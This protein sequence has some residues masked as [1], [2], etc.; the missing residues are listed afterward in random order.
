MIDETHDDID[1]TNTGPHNVTLKQW[2]ACAPFEKLLGMDI[3]ESG[4]GKAVLTM[5]FRYKLAQGL[6]LLHGGALFSL[7]DTA[8]VMAMKSLLPDS[9]H[10]ATISAECTFLSAVTQGTVTAKAEV[11]K[12]EGRLLYGNAIV[13]DTHGKQVLEFSSVFKIARKQRNSAGK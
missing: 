4:G 7:A 2:I 9:T 10:F 12:Q 8:V 5:P 11:V 1:V 3:V 13:F 6:G